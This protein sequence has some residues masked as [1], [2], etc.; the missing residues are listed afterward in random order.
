[1]RTAEALAKRENCNAIVM[2]DS[3]GQVASQTLRNMRT[4]Q[5]VVGM[6]IIRPL[7]GMDKDQIIRIAR[8]IRTFELS[9]EG[10]G[11]C[12]IV[13]SK[14]STGASLDR[15]LAAESEMDVQEM[16]ENALAEIKKN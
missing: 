2:G 10:A 8:K 9:I 4:E 13:P 14:P 11:P 1:M 15:I 3:M 12:G 16:I 5:Q 6:P 7:I